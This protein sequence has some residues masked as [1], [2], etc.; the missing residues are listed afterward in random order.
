MATAV[1]DLFEKKILLAPLDWG[2]GH[3]SRC[4][5]LIKRL[6]G[7]NNHFVIACTVKQKQFLQEEL[8]GV[9]Y[10][11]LFG[12]D[13]MYS[14]VLPLW[15]KILL[16]L[17]RI[18][19]IIRKEHRWLAD[20]VKKNKVDFIISDNRFGFYHEKVESIFIT[21]Q[22]NVQV[23]VFKSIINRINVSFIKKYAAC[24]VPDF[25]EE[26][27]SLSGILSK[28][29]TGLKNIEFI[30]PLSRFGKKET[31]QKKYD[32]FI[33]LSGPEPQRTLLEDKLV[34]ACISTPYT[35]VLV[36]GTS[37]AMERKLP[38]NFSILDVVSSEQLQELFSLSDK[39][40]CRSGYSTLMDLH[41]LERKALLI[42][43]PGQTEQEYLAKY[44]HE[45]LGYTFVE[46]KNISKESIEVFM[47]LQ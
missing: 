20:Y 2:L 8:N 31:Q 12:Y 45:K 42:P 11:D 27:K 22:L 16:Q 38:L 18:S 23:P 6:Q 5:P 35:I 46:Q 37:K 24:W 19:S 17:P 25:K 1:H 34:S 13:V 36:R 44:W 26:K 3:A 7:Q 39:V 15:I 33:L 30:G 32:V 4:V 43:T 14:T 41:A 21:H 9:E 10:V 29:N 47:K 28:G 40:I